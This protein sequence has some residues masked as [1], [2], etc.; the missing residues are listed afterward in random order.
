MVHAF[1]PKFK[2]FVTGLCFSPRLQVALLKSVLLRNV[3]SW[4]NTLHV[5]PS[6]P[7]LTPLLACC[8]LLPLAMA[9]DLFFWCP[10]FNLYAIC[11]FIPE[12]KAF[13]LKMPQ[14]LVSWRGQ[15]RPAYSNPTN[16]EIVYPFVGMQICVCC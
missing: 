12:V 2:E 5:P 4:P 15:A 8:P 6:C 1:W 10:F 9:Y 11:Q 13:H 16:P 3:F 14:L 7:S